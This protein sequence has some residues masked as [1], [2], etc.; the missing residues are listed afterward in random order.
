MT[1]LRRRMDRA[2]ERLLPRS[3]RGL[4]P[5]FTGGLSPQ[6]ISE[7]VAVVQR[8]GA[9]PVIFC[10]APQPPTGAPRPSI[11]Q[12]DPKETP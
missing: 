1:D 8:A 10:A 12:L 9:L 3:R 5:V 4:V 7:A 2:E 11:V 6:Q